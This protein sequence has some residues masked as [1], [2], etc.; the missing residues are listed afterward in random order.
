MPAKALSRRRNKARKAL[1]APRR[2][3]FAEAVALHV[4]GERATAERRY[5]QILRRDRQ[6]ADAA[7]N[8]G[9]LLHERG[10]PR[11]GWRLYAHA[12][13][14]KDDPSFILNQSRI[15]WHGLHDPALALVTVHRGMERFP[16]DA[17]L[18]L[19]AALLLQTLGRYIEAMAHYREL[20]PGALDPALVQS[21]LGVCLLKLGHAT[22][23]LPHLRR[24]VELV[25]DD[26][27]Y[28]VNLAGGLIAARQLDEAARWVALL[29][30]D[31]RAGQH[32]PLLE[33]K[34]A[35][36]QM[37]PSAALAA[38]AQL[39]AAVAAQPY[40]SVLRG[41]ALYRLNRREEA[42]AV[43]E[44]A[45]AVEPNQ[46]DALIGLAGVRLSLKEYD[47]AHDLLQRAL[48]Q[49]PEAPAAQLNWGHWQSHEGRHAE[50]L[51]AYAAAYAGEATAYR[52][53]WMYWQALVVAN[54]QREA[55]GLLEAVLTHPEA[56][57]S[58][59]HYGTAGVEANFGCFDRAVQRFGEQE[60]RARHWA[61]QQLVAPL[62][63][64]LRRTVCLL[65]VGR[66]GSFLFQAH[67]DGHPQILNAPGAYLKDLLSDRI[68]AEELSEVTTLAGLRVLLERLAE[69]Y[70]VFFDS[71][72]TRKLPS[73]VIGAGDD[74]GRLAGYHHL[75]P[76]RDQILVLPRAALLDAVAQRLAPSLG[77]VALDNRALFLALHEA[78]HR[79]LHPQATPEVLFFHI[80]NPGTETLVKSLAALQPAEQWLIVR[81][82]LQALERWMQVNAAAQTPH[83]DPQFAGYCRALGVFYAFFSSVFHP[84][85]QW[86]ERYVVRLEDLKQRPRELFGACAAHLEV[87]WSD[88][89]LQPT[90]VGVDYHGLVHTAAKHRFDASHLDG[91]RSELFSEDDRQRLA[92]LFAVMRQAF[93]YAPPGAVRVPEAVLRRVDQPFDF[94]LQFQ[95]GMTRS[96]EELQASSV[97]FCF[98]R[99]YGQLLSL[100]PR[101]LAILHGRPSFKSLL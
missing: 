48:A 86:H 50:A 49:S 87:D 85:I 98:H 46:I 9:T 59:L 68:V 93:G 11:L 27:N 4:A 19:Q 57:E 74:E 29:R 60:Q 34:L 78:L 99:Y 73:S 44:A 71:R 16:H 69:R 52:N 63:P 41:E 35:M 79:L 8:L 66:A 96:L 12:L 64:A 88:V 67:W 76:E 31:R 53:L 97:Y 3:L 17:G 89:L 101:I 6:H 90:V 1:Q 94:E 54:C 25:S 39:P 2:D 15:A 23:A 5:R 91:Y 18:R 40:P 62:P 83:R 77:R 84:S 20:L 65:P 30:A 92:P 58:S 7:A 42:A 75:G 33:A 82:P 45:L 56:A 28:Q 13:R 51:A 32:L 21:N 24:G 43:L 22:Q 47:A 26:A 38:L 70:E 80:H 100:V 14:F 37:R 72:S 36:E 81:E 55:V 61:R 95:A 10:R